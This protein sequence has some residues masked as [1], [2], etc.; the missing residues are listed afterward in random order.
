MLVLLITAACP[1]IEDQFQGEKIIGVQLHVAVNVDVLITFFIFH[2]L[3][4]LFDQ[5][6]SLFVDT[7]SEEIK[8]Q[9]REQMAAD[10]TI[11]YWL[12]D[13]EV[14]EWNFDK[15]AE[16]QDFYVNE[17]GHIVVCFNEYDVAPG[18]MGCVEFTLN[19]TVN[20]K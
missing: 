16:D 17:D 20:V 2:A 12:D 4:E 10:E 7:I 5:L 14:E 15:I 8:T 3:F 6:I 13:P 18:S 19:E 1:L 11:Q 9:M